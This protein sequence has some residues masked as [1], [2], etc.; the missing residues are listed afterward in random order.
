MQ[1]PGFAL[2]GK[3]VCGARCR[4]RDG[5]RFRQAEAVFHAKTKYVH[6]T[7]TYF[8]FLCEQC[9]RPKQNDS[10]ARHATDRLELTWEW[11]EKPSYGQS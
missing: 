9:P 1:R 10:R 5:N 3:A 7:D 2:C 6:V 8:V 4:T 11:A